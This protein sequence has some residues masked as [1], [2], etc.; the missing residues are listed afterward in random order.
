[1]RLF[2]SRIT[3]SFDLPPFSDDD[4]TA[5]IRFR[6]EQ[7]QETKLPS[8]MMKFVRVASRGVPGK[9]DELL[10]TVLRSRRDGRS[11][12]QDGRV[13]TAEEPSDDGA[14]S[15]GRRKK[16]RWPYALTA[17]FLAGSGI[18][19]A[20]P[21][22]DALMKTVP[23]L[24]SI[25]RL[26]PR[27][28]LPE[29]EPASVVM[30]DV[31]VPAGGQSG[32]AE[33][34]ETSRLVSDGAAP[35]GG[36]R[37]GTMAEIDVPAMAGQQSVL[38]DTEDL[39]QPDK[40]V[41]VA[42]AGPLAD[43]GRRAAGTVAAKAAKG[44]VRGKSA[45]SVERVISLEERIL[46]DEQWLS[47]RRDSSYTLQLM[48]M[49][50]SAAVAFVSRYGLGD[51]VRYYRTR[52]EKE[53]LLAVTYGEYASLGDA[54]MAERSLDKKLQGVRPWVRGMRTI[55]RAIVR[56]GGGATARQTSVKEEAEQQI[57]GGLSE[58]EQWLMEQAPRHY[59]LQLLAMDEAAVER[60]IR[61]NRLE[62]KVRTFRLVSK[63]RSLVAAVSG[64]YASKAEA[65]RA[66]GQLASRISGTRPWVR[67]FASVQGVIEASPSVAQEQ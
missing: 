4:A 36:G 17:L 45:R 27:E 28:H 25:E 57:A 20:K 67:S 34:Q 2:Y 16:S 64:S 14:A 47:S 59:T 61:R 50:P 5:Y 30:A 39:R 46:N 53:S 29:E 38:A 1:M 60:F 62:G 24:A 7:M 58:H 12:I 66:A 10:A 31:V 48:A 13:S 6:L 52:G 44:G 49:K 23:G 26:L 56:A 9:M 63:G 55:K 21:E 40:P 19:L 3:H 11:L 41:A 37:Q 35:R 43:D 65:D 54:R 8:S 42:S 15:A 51:Q 33:G 22:L 32:A 18:W